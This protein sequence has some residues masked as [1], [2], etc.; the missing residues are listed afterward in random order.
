MDRARWELER[1]VGA[2][3]HGVAALAVGQG[4]DADRGA[5]GGPVVAGEE[6]AEAPERRRDL[7]AHH[8]GDG[9]ER[10]VGQ[11]V[12]RRGRHALVGRDLRVALD[13]G[14]PVLVGEDARRGGGVGLR[15]RD[16]RGAG[17]GGDQAR[18]QGGEDHRPP[19]G[20]PRGGSDPMPA[21][22]PCV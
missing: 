4:G 8:G 19:S 17:P 16:R 20:A 18:E 5:G 21:N 2:H 13:V 7:V 3:R 9:G 6:V 1:G 15:R 12:V 10:V 11:P 14:G 22:T